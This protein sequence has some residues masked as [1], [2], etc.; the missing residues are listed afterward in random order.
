MLLRDGAP[1]ALVVHRSDLLGDGRIVED[2]VS[3]ASVAFENE[4]LVAEA[5]ARL[6]ELR[7]SQARLVAAADHEREQLERDLHDGAQQRLVGLGLAMRV[8]RARQGAAAATIDAAERELGHA[9]DDL[10]ELA[11]GLHPAVLTHFGLA[12]ATRA[13]AERAADPVRIL[14]VPSARLPMAVERAAYQLLVEA[15]RSGPVTATLSHDAAGLVLDIETTGW[16]PHLDDVADRVGALDG[17][18]ATTAGPTGD[19]RIRAV[20][21]CA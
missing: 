2:V 20:I 5:Q 10:R 13:L 7:R 8:T 3:A 19:V 14:A 15:A 11:S 1:V 12:A 6:D 16:P 17:T 9:V 4:R 21:P 18:L